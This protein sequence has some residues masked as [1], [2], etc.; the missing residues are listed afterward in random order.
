MFRQVRI[1]LS[2]Q[3]LSEAVRVVL[4]SCGLPVDYVDNISLQKN[5]HQFMSASKENFANNSNISPDQFSDMVFSR[6][7]NRFEAYHAYDRSAIR[8]RRTARNTVRFVLLL[9][10]CKQIL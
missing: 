2:A 6:I 5:H 7:K 8:M 1:R 4:S 10:L 3:N 9:I